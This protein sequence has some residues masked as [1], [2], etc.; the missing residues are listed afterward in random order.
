M[1][2]PIKVKL[3]EGFLL[4]EMR[5]GYAVSEKLK[6]IWAV[7]ID[8]L[9]EL[10]RVCRKHNIKLQIFGGTLLGAVRH[11]GFIPW[12]DDL[13][14]CITRGEFKKLCQVASMEF[15]YPYFF[16]TALTDRRYFLPYARL[17]NCLTTAVVKGQD[18]PEYNN[19]IYI[20]IYVM[21]GYPKTS[22]GFKAHNALLMLVVKPVTLY[23]QDKARNAGWRE[24]ILRAPR[25]F[26]KILPYNFWLSV[27][28]FV[29]SII[30]P[31]T[32]RIGLRHEMSMRARRYWVMKNELADTID[33]QFEFLRVPAPRSFD[34]ILKRLYS[35]YMSFPLPSER[36][37][38]HAGSIIFEPDVPFREFFKHSA[39]DSKK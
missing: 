10:L 21:E 38:W 7:E 11:K 16:Q 39:D 29:L 9:N 22:F 14:V 1:S 25:P 20:D 30:T 15:S 18:A 2:L 32:N 12:D 13:D 36:G 35:E 34:A 24:K 6:K 26:V 31:F 28:Y 33:V 27:Y 5:C 37:A 8:L 23:Y 4:P 17:R 3:P 19:G